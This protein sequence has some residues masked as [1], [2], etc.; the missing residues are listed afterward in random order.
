MR[1]LQKVEMDVFE[2]MLARRSVRGY[3]A[4]DVDQVTTHILLE[5][6]VRAP[7]AMH[8]EPWA[9]VIIQDRTLLSNLSDR[10]KPLFLADI[11]T[12]QDSAEHANHTMDVLSKPDF[13]IFYD[14]GTLILICGKTDA[15][16]FSAD[17][18]LAAENLMLAACAMG[19]GSCVIG[20]AI[21]V[22][23]ISEVKAMLGIPNEFS[24]VAPIILG[25]AEDETVMPN[26]RKPPV[27][28]TSLAAT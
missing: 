22:F 2:T 23:N 13:N 24:V 12:Q 3:K 20:C 27:I 8:Q 7:T 15:A 28:L 19:L 5:A 9:F 21:P 25:F 17:C 1:P 10:A 18:W 4:Q 14:A 11:K 26:P 16:S 6:A